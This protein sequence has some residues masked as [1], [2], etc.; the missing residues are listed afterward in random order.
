MDKPLDIIALLRRGGEMTPA[1]MEQLA[2]ELREAKLSELGR[3][4]ADRSLDQPVKVAPLAGHPP[5]SAAGYFTQQK[6]VWHRTPEE[7]E[8][9]LGVFGKLREGAYILQ[10]TP[11][12]RSSDYENKAYSYLPDGKEYRPDP[13]EHVYLPGKGAPQWRLTAPMLVKCIAVL[14]P[15]ERFDRESLGLKK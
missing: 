12:L 9:I 4:V 6:F 13:S 2:R 14:R 10:F 1:E 15:G 5:T 11:A 3:G 8:A 7:M